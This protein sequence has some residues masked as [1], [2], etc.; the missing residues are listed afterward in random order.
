MDKNKL[1]SPKFSQEVIEELKRVSWPSRAQ[2][3]RLTAVVILISLTIGL[4]IGI[5]DLLLAKVLEIAT[6]L[7]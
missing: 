7:R 1:R 4:Y 6:T 2:T 3:I 5:I